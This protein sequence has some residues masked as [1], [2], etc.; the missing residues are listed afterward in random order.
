MIHW[1]GSAHDNA[2][3]ACIDCHR[4]H[5]PDPMR[6]RTSENETCFGCHAKQ[7]SEHLLPSAHPLRDGRMACSDCHA[8]HGSAGPT[9][10]A[11]DTVNETCT[12]C[13]AEFRGPFLWEHPPVREDCLTCHR[14]HGATQRALL[15]QRTPFLCQQCHL[16]QFHPST[17]QSGTGLPGA[18]LPSGSTSLLGRD[19]LN[20]HG[21]VHG[22]NHPSGP[23]A[24]R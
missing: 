17:A 22:S 11:A 21:Q 20:C 8:P 16:A 4:S 9:L 13:H 23:G 5:S 2:G 6:E 7:R 12:T 3:V 10:L 15:S 24:I 18:T 1:P 19:C 14:P